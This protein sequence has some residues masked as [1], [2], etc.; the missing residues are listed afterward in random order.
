MDDY[1]GSVVLKGLE[2]RAAEE[3]G[4]PRQPVSMIMTWVG[5]MSRSVSLLA[6]YKCVGN[7]EILEWYLS[8]LTRQTRDYQYKVD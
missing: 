3:G 4:L 6:F 1:L 7:S 2:F 8:S 5:G